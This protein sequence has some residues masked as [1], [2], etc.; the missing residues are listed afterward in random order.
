MTLPDVSVVIASRH[1]PK[2]LQRVLTAPQWARL[3]AAARAAL[4][5]PLSG[6]LARCVVLPGSGPAG[7]DRRPAKQR[8]P[9]RPEP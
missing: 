7:A 3:E 2:L 8:G 1:R 6:A 9:T 4:P 5:D